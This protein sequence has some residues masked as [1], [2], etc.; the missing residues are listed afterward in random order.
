MGCGR[1]ASERTPS[2][3]TKISFKDMHHLYKLIPSFLS[4]KGC[5]DASMHPM[6]AS[7]AFLFFFKKRQ[8]YPRDRWL[9]LFLFKCIHLNK[10][11]G[12]MHHASCIMHHASCIMHHASC[13]MHPASIAVCDKGITGTIYIVLVNYMLRDE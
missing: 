5:I 3:A 2:H 4:F 12:I 9:P 11:S 6:G 1:G 8:N 7:I 13:I 10:K